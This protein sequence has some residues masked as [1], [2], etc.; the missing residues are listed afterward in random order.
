MG[1]KPP[2]FNNDKIEPSPGKVETILTIR[3][4]EFGYKP[5]VPGT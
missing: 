4:L 3:N 2:H 5:H 1:Y